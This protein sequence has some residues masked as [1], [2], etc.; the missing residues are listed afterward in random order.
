MDGMV[1]KVAEIRQKLS[2]VEHQLE[3]AKIEVTKPFPQ[4]AELEEKMNRLT[5]LNALLN[6]K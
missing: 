5:A 2:N 4:K 3:T 1:T 6:F